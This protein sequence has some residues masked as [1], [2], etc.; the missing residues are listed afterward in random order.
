M[1]TRNSTN[2]TRRDALKLGLSTTAAAS[3]PHW[4]VE[5]CA[6]EETSSKETKS[7]NERPRVALIGCGGMGMGDAAN[8]AKFGDIVALCDV[9]KSH[10]DKAKQKYKKAKT[11][12]DYRQVCDLPNIDVI[13]NYVKTDMFNDT[14]APKFRKDY[15]KDAKLILFPRNFGYGRGAINSVNATDRP[16]YGTKVILTPVLI[17]NR[18]PAT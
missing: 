8:A 4:F 14:V 9:D 7:P 13:L 17:L 10:L 1:A 18:A 2:W 3:L 5:R 15:P 6:G 11:Y 12:S 16:R